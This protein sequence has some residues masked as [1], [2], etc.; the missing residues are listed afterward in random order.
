[1]VLEFLHQTVVLRHR[2]QFLDAFAG[3]HG[4]RGNVGGDLFQGGVD[5]TLGVH[6]RTRG[7]AEVSQPAVP[8]DTHRVDHGKGQVDPVV[9]ES[10]VVPVQADTVHHVTCSWRSEE[11]RAGKE[12][13]T[14]TAP[15]VTKQKSNLCTRSAI[16][17]EYNTSWKSKTPRT[18]RKDFAL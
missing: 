14:E 15:S 16:T 7:A 1:M 3:T 5:G 4:Q 18:M 13:R 11:R 6:G 12:N 17:D 9:E 8:S 10:D 2:L